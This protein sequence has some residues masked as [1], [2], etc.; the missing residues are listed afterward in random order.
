[1]QREYL[2][3]AADSIQDLLSKEKGQLAY[4]TFG[5]GSFRV[6]SKSR[7][8]HQA[9]VKN[10]PL[11]ADHLVRLDLLNRLAVIEHPVLSDLIRMFLLKND[12]KLTGE[13][14]ALILQEGDS[15]MQE[16]LHVLLEDEDSKIRVSA[17]I[18]LA[19]IAQDQTVLKYLYA[20]YPKASREMKIQILDA[21]GSI[22][23]RE[24]IPFLEKSMQESSQILRIISASSLLRVLRG[25]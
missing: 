8:R 22:K 10:A 4:S 13:M 11:L 25:G 18:A 15:K 21:L 14:A 9:G 5:Q 12:W 19:F 23:N 2:E 1:M 3:E 6:L 17:A 7:I 24:S 20:A 16:A